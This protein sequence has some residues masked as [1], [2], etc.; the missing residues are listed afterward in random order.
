MCAMSAAD[1]C[2]CFVHVCI[3]CASCGC[4]GV[5]HGRD[6]CAFARRLC[7][8]SMPRCLSTPHSHVIDSCFGFQVALVV[9]LSAELVSG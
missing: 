4:T 8:T 6:E 2:E 9:V 1:G 5:E 3:C 7:R